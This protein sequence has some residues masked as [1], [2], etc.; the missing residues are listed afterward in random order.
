MSLFYINLFNY[1]F[2]QIERLIDTYE[3]PILL[4]E[5]FSSAFER[6]EW[7]KRKKHVYGAL[8]YIFLRKQVPIIPT[9]MPN[10]SSNL[11]AVWYINSLRWTMII[12]GGM[13]NVLMIAAM[14]S[15]LPELVAILAMPLLAPSKLPTASI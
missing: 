8:T 11:C 10:L 9:S 14:I 15:V 3:Q 1:L 4:L 7:K 2:E 12:V 13:S 6:T 5:N